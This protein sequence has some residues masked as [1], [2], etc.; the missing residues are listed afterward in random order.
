[1]LLLRQLERLNVCQIYN[2]S[3]I[4]CLLS[5]IFVYFRDKIYLSMSSFMYQVMAVAEARRGDASN[6]TRKL[7]AFS[8]KYVK[9]FEE[10]MARTRRLMNDYVENQVMAFCKQRSSLPILKLE[11]TG[12][13][14]ERLK[15][16]AADEVDVMVVLKTTRGEIEVVG[17]GISGY[18][19]LMARGG[20]V[21]RGYASQ[22]GYVDPV[23]LRD[24]WFYSLVVQAVNNFNAKSPFAEVR[25]VVRYHGPAVQLDILKRGTNEKFLSVDLV[26]CFQLGESCYVAKPYKGSY[27]VSNHQLLWR[28]SFSLQEKQILEYMDRD[29]G[30]RHELL[31]IVKTVVKKQ[32]T[33]LPL[34][35]YYLKTAF[36]HYIKGGGQQNWVSGDALGNHFLG[37]LR[38]L[39]IFLERRDLPHYWLP[40]VNLL[41]DIAQV[42]TRNMAYRLQAIL[43]S[44]AE[45]NIILS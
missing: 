13:V 14:Y 10:N 42:V 45:R 7:R 24:G 30:C 34:E 32:A 39:Q 31:R 27:P 23:R 15:T 16:E 21:F 18:V 35:S 9:I 40:G 29:G 8:V 37:F 1:M 25:L 12:S 38:A 22:E 43:N 20:S 17:S 11:Y 4:G 19:R 28:Q 44:E 33:S 41:D 5:V 3:S 2:I 36:L 26:P 6:L